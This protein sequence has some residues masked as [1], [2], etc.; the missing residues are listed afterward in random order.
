VSEEIIPAPRLR[1]RVAVCAHRG[2]CG[3][4]PE[5]TIPALEKAIELGC[6]AVEIDVRTTADGEIVV[7]HNSTVDATTNGTGPVAEFTLAEIRGLDA[8][9]HFGPQFAGTRVPT[10]AEA[11]EC[12]KGRTLVVLEVKQATVDAILRIVN[13]CRAR[14]EVA[15]L[16]GVEWLAELRARD[17]GISVVAQPWHVDEVVPALERLKPEYSIVRWKP[18]R[19]T[20][21]FYPHIIEA[22]HRYGTQIC[23][24]VLGQKDTP[25]GVRAVI[26][27]GVDI[28]ETDEPEMVM[29]VAGEMGAR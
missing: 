22:C 26:T 1:E 24:N 12:C 17:A 11:L 29:A 14:E 7:M 9:A 28:I 2:A 25:E 5:N 6:E 8:G 3:L 23:Q 18:G 16:T 20:N 21:T 19:E 27:A 4:A 10:L 15:V 13:D